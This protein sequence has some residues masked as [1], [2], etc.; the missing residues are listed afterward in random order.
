MLCFESSVMKN[1]SISGLFETIFLDIGDVFRTQ[2]RLEERGV[3]KLALYQIC[4]STF[5]ILACLIGCVNHFQNARSCSESR[6]YA[7]G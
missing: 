7:L 6:E 4:S 3:I 2:I 5:K 1:C